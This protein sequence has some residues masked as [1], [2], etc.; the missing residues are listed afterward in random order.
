MNISSSYPSPE[1]S[2]IKFPRAAAAIV[3]IPR[4]APIVI[5]IHSPYIILTPN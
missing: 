3:D 4:T 2:D 1:R 5:S